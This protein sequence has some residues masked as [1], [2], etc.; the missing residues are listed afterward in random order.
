LKQVFPERS[1]LGAFG[2]TVVSLSLLVAWARELRPAWL[3]AGLVALAAAAML[4]RAAVRRSARPVPGALAAALG[5]LLLGHVAAL[6][7]AWQFQRMERDWPTVVAEREATVGE[8]LGARMAVVVERG[9]AAAAN[10]AV[11]AARPRGDLFRQLGVLREQW[12][13]DALAV[14]TDAGDLVAWAG[15]HRGPLPDSVWLRAAG[16]Y[17]EERPLFSYLYFSVPVAGRAE[18]AVSAVLVETGIVGAGRD[19]ATADIVAARTRTR[20]SF[21][22]GA[23]PDA[24]W[25]LAEAGDTIVHARLDALTQADWRRLLER[26]GRRAAVIALAGA[27][28]ALSVAWLRWVIPVRAGL[29]VAVPLLFFSVLGGTAPLRHAL[30]ADRFFSPLLFALPVPGDISLGR[31]LAILLPLGALAASARRSPRPPGRLLAA[32]LLGAAALAAAYPV[33]IRLM[34]DSATPALLQHPAALWLGLQFAAVIA[35]AS[36]THVALPC[37]AGPGPGWLGRPMRHAL[38]A[39]ALLS[40]TV[41]AAI[42]VLVPAPDAPLQPVVAALWAVPF[43]LAAVALAPLSGRGGSLARWLCASWLA[44]TAVLPHVWHEQLEARLAAAEA[45]LETLGTQA[46]P[47][48]DYLLVAFAREAS[49]RFAGGEEGMQ[50]LYRTW[51]ASGLAQEP[52]PARIVLWTPDGQPAV[53]LGVAPVLMEHEAERLT[54]MVDEAREERVSLVMQFTDLPN[55]SKL[56]TVPLGDGSLV[57][58]V[59]PPRRSLDRTSAV[60]PFL[61]VVAESPVR[62]TLVDATGPPVEPQTIEWLPTAEGWRA[63]AA[64]QYPDGWY[65]VNLVVP[66]SGFGMRLVRGALLL[67]FNLSLLTLLWLAGLLAQGRPAVKRGAWRGWVGSFRARVTLALFGF[68]LVPTAVFGWAAYNALAGEVARSAQRIAQH[69]VHQAVLEF[70]DE[71]GDLRRLALHAG[72]DVLRYHGGELIDVSSREALDLGVYSAWLPPHIFQRLEAGAAREAVETQTLG[73]HSFVTAYRTLPPTGTLGVPM[74]LTAGETALRLRELAHLVLFAAVMGALL[75]LALSV[76]VGR[77]LAGPIGQLRR[78][79]VAVGAGSLRPRLPERTS[80]EFGQVFAAFNRMTRRLRRARARELRTARVLAWGEMARQ[81][82]HEIKNPLTPIKLSVQHLRRAHRDRHPRFDEILDGN[83]SQIL[84]EIDRLSDIA[85]AFSRYGAPGFAAGPLAS[86][87]VPA[88]IREALMLYR[89]GDRHVVYVD[90]VQADLPRV[91]A[92]PD[93]LKE[94][95]L[96][97][98]ENARAAL[99]GPGRVEIRAAAHGEHVEI[100]VADDGPGIPASLLPRI[101]EP[102]FSTRSTGTGLGLAIV[103]RLVESWGGTVTAESDAGQGTTMRIRLLPARAGTGAA[104]GAVAADSGAGDG[105]G[106]G[107]GDAPTAPGS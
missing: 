20:A 28:I 4:H 69:A 1:V 29:A 10:A 107:A 94:V 64:V 78:A 89:S 5:V 3:L 27:V 26:G 22:R 48:L 9:R 17:F 6:V 59:V 11:E 76:A 81:V 93:E 13:V 49:A 82:A 36:I 75:S 65:S 87:D 42:S 41:L 12:G 79:V 19:G 47:F 43:L 54:A 96:N 46:D 70:A 50:L 92:R 60:A 32:A 98:V 67:A 72:T 103:R 86:V 74:P 24:V 15:E 23:A 16:A 45:E 91:M 35:L 52:Y 77:A 58:V 33:V 100:E 66:V 53:Q 38:L 88:V 84:T 83:V 90:S 63:D 7:F 62:L 68:F 106:A 8:A 85:R 71:A 51:V 101:F 44:G 95:L 31:L 25:A 97:L 80:D 14:Y 39:A 105:R 34:L 21:R 40:A 30:G 56:L 2:A 37:T 99:E 55:V 57:T 104:G 18:R 102:H 61:G 73:A